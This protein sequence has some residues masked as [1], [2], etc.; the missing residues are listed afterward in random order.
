MGDKQI[1]D[2]LLK[3]LKSADIQ[4]DGKTWIPVGGIV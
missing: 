2:Y 1:P 3:L 4:P